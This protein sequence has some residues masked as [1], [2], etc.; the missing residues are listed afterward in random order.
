[1]A[2]R[3]LRQT[4]VGKIVSRAEIP[5]LAALSCPAQL[6]QFMPMPTAIRLN[7]VSILRLPR[8]G[9]ANHVGDPE[10]FRILRLSY[11]EN[12]KIGDSVGLGPPRPPVRIMVNDLI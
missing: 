11:W 8:Q 10:R 4:A 1:M 12:L 9:S 7:T 6:P 2:T 5:G 3:T